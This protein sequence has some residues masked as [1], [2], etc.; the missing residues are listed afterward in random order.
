MNERIKHLREQGVHFVRVLWCDNAN[1][2]RAKAAHIDVVEEGG[3]AV[4]I[5]AAQQALPVMYDA[6]V[7]GS[8][9]GPVG[10]VQLVPDWGTLHTLPYLPG[11]AE[12]VGDMTMRE[13]PWEH[14]PRGFL[15]EQVARLGR[16]E[17]EVQ[18]AFENEFF[19]LRPS[20][21]QPVSADDTVFAA[22]QA[23]N[24]VGELVLELTEALTAQGLKVE[25]YYPES[26]PGQH[27][28]AVH[29]RTALAAA[30]Q[31]LVYRETVRA[32]AARHG[33]LASF[34][35]KIFADKAG[36]GCHLNL[37]L[38]QG[39]KNVT[40][41]RQEKSGLGPD[42]QAFIAGVL[43][44]LKGL[45]ALTIPS[46]NSYRRIR[47]HFW[48]GAFT[49]W[50][51]DNREAAVR[52]FAGGLNAPPKRFEIKCVDAT[53]NPY[54]AL[55]AVLAAGLDGIKRGLTLPKE[56]LGDPALMSE[57]ERAASGVEP[58]PSTLG[59]AIAELERDDV[60]LA[61]LGEARAQTYLAV[62]RAEWDAL[63]DAT[64]EDEVA[65]LLGRY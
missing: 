22:A 64:L 9:L 21:E 1:V 24:G 63:K 47:P 60:L 6:V 39:G 49:A 18:A 25:T 62:R 31:Q 27:E 11:Y 37:S 42:A 38:W 51:Y 10:E 19:L 8:G 48:A 36:S 40:G 61:A 32:V 46:A 50:G 7:E 58:L 20:H 34:L 13:Q 26:G 33:L 53:A 12:V 2:I 16:H 15:K 14:C 28:L 29:Y 4:G 65:L 23:M 17:L 54:L 30:D 43:A 41:D 56:A 57:T 5:S 35:P 52:V 44:H 3:G 59:G 45:C 55:G